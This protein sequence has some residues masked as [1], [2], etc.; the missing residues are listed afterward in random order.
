[1][2]KKHITPEIEDAAAAAEQTPPPPPDPV[3]RY[4]GPDYT[5]G[6]RIGGSPYLV[7]PREMPIAEAKILIEEHPKCAA[8][9]LLEN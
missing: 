9:W 1:M 2:A 3:W 5:E 7:R 6:I 8:W 4:V